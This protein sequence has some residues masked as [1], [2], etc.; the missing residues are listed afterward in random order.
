MGTTIDAESLQEHGDWHLL[1]EHFQTNHQRQEQA[2]SCSTPTAKAATTS[3]SPRSIR[4]Q[5]A[6]QAGII[7]EEQAVALEAMEETKNNNH[8]DIQPQRLFA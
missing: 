4:Y 2:E 1:R 3:S 8:D 5:M 7:S 6:V